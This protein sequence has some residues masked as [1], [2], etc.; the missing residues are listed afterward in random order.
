MVIDRD[1]ADHIPAF[2]VEL[3]DQSGRGHAFTGALAAYCA[4]EDD[5]RGAVKFASAAGALACTRFGL[6]E[7]LPTKADIIQLL[8]KEDTEQEI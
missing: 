2:D 5:V 8:Q 7:A 3:V 1:G 4:I 6:L